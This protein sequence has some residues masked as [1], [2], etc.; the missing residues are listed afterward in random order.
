MQGYLQD[1]HLGANSC[2]LLEGSS[3]SRVGRKQE[4]RKEHE[5]YG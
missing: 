4:E 3:I 2:R 5:V 1:A